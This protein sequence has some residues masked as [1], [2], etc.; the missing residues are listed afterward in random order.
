M[1]QAEVVGQHPVERLEHSG[2]GAASRNRMAR[3][4][5]SL[6]SLYRMGAEVGIVPWARQAAGGTVI[7]SAPTCCRLGL[8]GTMCTMLYPVFSA[9]QWVVTR[10]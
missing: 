5:M 2:N 10:Y 1:G 4:E 9:G 6:P 3:L 7:T 8:D